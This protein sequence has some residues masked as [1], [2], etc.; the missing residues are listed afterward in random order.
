MAFRALAREEGCAGGGRQ[1]WG[2][3]V[4]ED[5]ASEPGEELDVAVFFSSRVGFQSNDLEPAF[6]VSCAVTPAASGVAL[7]VTGLVEEAV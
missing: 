6:S 4:D 5:W 7:S 3:A 2:G 1:T